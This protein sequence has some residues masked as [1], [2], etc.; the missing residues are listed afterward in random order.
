MKTPTP[1]TCH[2]ESVVWR[3]LRGAARA[4]ALKARME[5]TMAVVNI[6]VCVGVLGKYK[7]DIVILIVRGSDGEFLANGC[8]VLLE[9]LTGAV[10]AGA[11]NWFPRTSL[12]SCN[13][14]APYAVAVNINS[15]DLP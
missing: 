13:V 10:D 12:Y 3:S 2:G 4:E 11:L 5:E 8:F 1:V 6:M 9:E 15:P 7:L 14:H